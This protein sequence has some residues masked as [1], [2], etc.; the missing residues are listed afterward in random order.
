MTERKIV[1]AQRKRLSAG[2]DGRRRV[3]DLVKIEGI[4]AKRFTRANMANKYAAMGNSLK[5]PI[6]KSG[7]N[8]SIHEAIAAERAAAAKAARIRSGKKR[9]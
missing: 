9:K 8:R 3:T 5:R 7:G 6:Y 2:R 1:Y 4:M